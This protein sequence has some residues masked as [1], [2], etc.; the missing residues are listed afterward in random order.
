MGLS[1]R[2]REKARRS[3]QK[4]F[5]IKTKEGG[6]CAEEEGHTPITGATEVGGRRFLD[7]ASPRDM[8]AGEGAGVASSAAKAA[9]LDV[10]CFGESMA[11]SVTAHGRHW[12]RVSAAREARAEARDPRWEGKS[13][14][15]APGAR[16]RSSPMLY[17]KDPPW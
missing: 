8:V 17:A 7:F 9:A 1:A 15:A 16:A 2:A 6:P 3:R 12:R 4:T 13:R 5:S 10:S 14:Q 11:S